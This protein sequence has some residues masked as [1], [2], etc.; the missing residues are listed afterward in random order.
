MN[1]GLTDPHTRGELRCNK[2]STS[3]PRLTLFD[4]F[5]HEDFQQGYG[6]VFN[7]SV[8]GNGNN[9][10]GVIEPRMDCHIETL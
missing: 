9:P 1:I 2:P 10:V 8:D 5:M 7:N 4:Y 6:T 3:V